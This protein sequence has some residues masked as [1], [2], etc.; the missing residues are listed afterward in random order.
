MEYEYCTEEYQ[1]NYLIKLQRANRRIKNLNAYKQM[2]STYE[3][4]E[5]T[6]EIFRQHQLRAYCVM[7]LKVVRKN[8]FVLD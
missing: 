1:V 6:D 2:A 8:E 5:I 3:I 7:K 4:P